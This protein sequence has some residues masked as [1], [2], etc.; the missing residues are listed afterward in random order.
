MAV[1]RIPMPCL[2]PQR[3]N[4]GRV[5]NLPRAPEPID[6]GARIL[7]MAPIA[8]ERTAQIGGPS[9]L[10]KLSVLVRCYDKVAQNLGLEA[11]NPLP[12]CTSGARLGSLS[13]EGGGEI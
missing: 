7:G 8:C 9:T 13:R 5:D 12:R 6:A 4:E 10:N 3:I 1:C 11:K 2:L